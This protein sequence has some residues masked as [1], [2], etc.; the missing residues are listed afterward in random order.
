M[1]QKNSGILTRKIVI[2]QNLWIQLTPDQ[3][4]LL[5]EV[6]TYPEMHPLCRIYS[7]GESSDGAKIFY[8]TE[9]V[10]IWLVEPFQALE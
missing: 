5:D 2:A 6:K 10:K 1:A 3:F 9:K 8:E 7:L 4:S